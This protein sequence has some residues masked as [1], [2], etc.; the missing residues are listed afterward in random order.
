MGAGRPGP[1]AVAPAHWWRRRRKGRGRE[2]ETSCCRKWGAA[3]VKKARRPLQWKRAFCWGGL[4]RRK[5]I[6]GTRG[7]VLQMTREPARAW[8]MNAADPD[9][10]ELARQHSLAAGGAR[11]GRGASR[12]SAGCGRRHPAGPHGAS[13][14]R[15][16]RV[17]PAAVAFRSSSPRGVFRRR[18]DVTA[19]TVFVASWRR[20]SGREVRVGSGCDYKGVHTAV[21]RTRRPI[22][23]GRVTV[24]D[25]V[26]GGSLVPVT[27]IHHG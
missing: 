5:R 25:L 20:T 26:S 12:T 2:E 16:R 18:R 23:R 8:G 27:P 7:D 21:A 6:A 1:G 4:R 17:P 24:C 9:G 14:N 10:S 19:V 15:P 13:Q 3:R 11:R 22:A